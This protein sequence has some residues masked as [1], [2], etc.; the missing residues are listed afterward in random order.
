MRLT[1]KMKVP[2]LFFP[3]KSLD[4]KIKSLESEEEKEKNEQR[5]LSDFVLDD[6]ESTSS[7]IEGLTYER[8]YPAINRKDISDGLFVSYGSSE[9]IVPFLDI[10]KFQDA[11]T[12]KNNIGNMVT[13]G[14]RFNSQDSTLKLYIMFKGQY[15]CFVYSEDREIV[16]DYL[17]KF[18]FKEIYQ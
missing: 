15:S 6:R 14:R 11:Q 9:N 8:C 2:D 1:R 5:K 10:F 3:E 13:C 17:E 7:E 18:G 4:E 12:M 16:D